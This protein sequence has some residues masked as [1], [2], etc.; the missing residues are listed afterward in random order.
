MI[1][2]RLTDPADLYLRQANAPMFS[3]G[4][5]PHD[6]PV[7]QRYLAALRQADGGDMTALLEFVRSS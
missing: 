6:E 1:D 5:A 3:W 2:R 7:R 4:P